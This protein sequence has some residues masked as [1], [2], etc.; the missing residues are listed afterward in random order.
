MAHPRSGNAGAFAHQSAESPSDH[1]GGDR[2]PGQGSEPLG[3]DD[4]DTGGDTP[5]RQNPGT[6]RR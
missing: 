1:S 5:S 3:G 2:N 6:E 4:G